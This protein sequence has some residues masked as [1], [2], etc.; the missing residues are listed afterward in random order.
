MKRCNKASSGTCTKHE[1]QCPHMKNHS[2]YTQECDPKL[3]ESAGL[4][5]YCGHY[6]D[7][8]CEEVEVI[9]KWEDVKK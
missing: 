4:T 9:F 2:F 1:N 5:P 8:V 7:Q 3:R 6:K